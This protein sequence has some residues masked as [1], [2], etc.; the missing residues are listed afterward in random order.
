M[1]IVTRDIIQSI[2]VSSWND[3]ATEQKRKYGQ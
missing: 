2:R 3:S 1:D